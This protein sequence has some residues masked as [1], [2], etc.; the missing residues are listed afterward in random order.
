ME[1]VNLAAAIQACEEGL[2]L[3]ALHPT[4]LTQSRCIQLLC[5]VDQ[6]RPPLFKA[7]DPTEAATQLGRGQERAQGAMGLQ[8]RVRVLS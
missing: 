6:P 5:L 3:Y 1:G 7:A 2:K 4:R 8:S